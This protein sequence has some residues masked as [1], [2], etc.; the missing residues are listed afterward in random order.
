MSEYRAAPLRAEFNK[1]GN[2]Q[3]ELL[4]DFLVELKLIAHSLGLDFAGALAG[5]E[6]H[7]LVE[8]G[9]RPEPFSKPR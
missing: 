6:G 9:Q 5:A 3:P 4:V 7:Y 1:A 2:D 8:S